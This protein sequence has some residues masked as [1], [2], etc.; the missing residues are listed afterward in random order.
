MGCNEADL[1]GSL[2]F[3]VLP[4][5][6]DN[7]NPGRQKLKIQ[8]SMHCLLI[9]AVS[10]ADLLASWPHLRW[11]LAADSSVSSKHY[12]VKGAML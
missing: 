2:I 6:S 4:T 9:L 10:A 12:M 8:E 1:A 5:G 7:R 11:D 3:P